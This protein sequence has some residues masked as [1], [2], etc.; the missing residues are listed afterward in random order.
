MSVIA[1]R[2]RA[3][4][5][6][7]AVD[8]WQVIVELIAPD[9][10][11]ARRELL[12]IEGIAASTIS[13]ESPKDAPMVVRGKGPRVRIYCLFNDEAVS[14]DD[15]NESALAQCPTEGEWSMSLPADSDD[16]AWVRDALAKKSKR[17]TVR[18]KS[19]D[20]SDDEDGA[21]ERT[22]TEAGINMEAF[23]RP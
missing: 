12:S 22:A 18:D 13:T 14:G 4:P 11:D 23:L 5:E 10:G 2:V 20:M 21:A 1:R 19:E 3:T 16:V 8:A 17:V 7:G 9:E 6:R 15:A